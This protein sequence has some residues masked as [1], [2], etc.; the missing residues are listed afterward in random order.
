MDDFTGLD[1]G[2]AKSE[3]LN[4]KESALNAEKTI[5][6][7]L[8]V[9]FNELSKKWASPNAVDFTSEYTTKFANEVQNLRT[10]IFHV[11]NGA[12]DAGNILARANGA[13][14]LSAIDS[15]AQALYGISPGQEAYAPEFAK[16][17]ETLNG[18]TGMAVENVKIIRD[19]FIQKIMGGMDELSAV[20]KTISFYSTD[21]SLMNSYQTGIDTIISN[22]SNE[23]VSIKESLNNFIETEANN[24]ILAKQQATDT[25]RA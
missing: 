3:I 23:L 20:P 10:S 15:L 21:G 19:V 24:I 7:S 14:F 18:A 5:T 17:R 1:I 13:N 4:F 16:C 8:K 2:K 11:I 12:I 22:F 25:L 6:S 9:F